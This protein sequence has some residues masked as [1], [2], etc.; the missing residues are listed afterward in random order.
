MSGFPNAQNNDAAAI[1]VRVTSGGG[2]GGGGAEAGASLAAIAV[3]T[4]SGLLIAAGTFKG[5]VT[6]QNTHATAI[7]YLSFNATATTGDFALQPG[8]A[9]TLAFGPTNDLHAIGSAAAT[10]A[11]VGY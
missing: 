10:V 8:S 6:I 9:I 1:P 2:S 4:S 7:V 3:G 5:W 11:A